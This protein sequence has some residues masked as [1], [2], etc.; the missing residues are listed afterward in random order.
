MNAPF[1]S[2][3]VLRLGLLALLFAALLTGCEAAIP[4][5]EPNPVLVTLPAGAGQPTETPEPPPT[6]T[7]VPTPTLKPIAATATSPA[8]LSATRLLWQLDDLIRP[9]ALA[10]TDRRL[11]AVTAD[12]RFLWV[13]AQTGRVEASAFLW[14]GILESETQGDVFT[15]GVLA[16]VSVFEQGTN[17]QTGRATSRSRLAIYDA[18]ANRLW[19]LPQMPSGRFYS[20]ALADDTVIAGT[21]PYGYWDNALAAYDLFTGEQVWRVN[22]NQTGFRQIVYHDGALY[23][24]LSE[25]SRAAAVVSYDSRTG[26]ER[27]RWT[28]EA[29][30]DPER[31]ILD[32]ERL[33]VATASSI[34]ALD[35]ASGA[36]TWRISFD[37][38]PEAGIVFHQ[39]LL[40]VAPV[41]TVELGFRPGVVGIDSF[42]G[43][44]A[45][46][47]LIGLVADALAVG[48]QALW[49]VG[50]DYDAGLV[51]L[52]GLEPAT[53]LERLRLPIA[54]GTDVI[55]RLYPAG[56][57]VYVLGQTLQV[58]G[59]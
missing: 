26:E 7:P 30:L 9:T 39:G 40:Y 20:A 43:E 59:Y 42:S 6:V 38:A 28:D 16:A 45:W 17:A 19:E 33:F 4:T 47:S 49:V 3:R 5:A 58:Y 55:Y 14:P 2:A 8:G 21:W 54:G 24:L 12:G 51:T 31:I 34:T 25:R 32:G 57:R 10:V 52:S 29:V 1:L 46:H 53:G 23:V 13:D 11:A 48:D 50:K 35:A 41:P 22:E 56:N 44:L 36:P 15:D 18:G 37:I 27:W